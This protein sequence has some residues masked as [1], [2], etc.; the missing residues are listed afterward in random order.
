MIRC[1]YKWAGDYI[2]ELTK[3]ISIL[4]IMWVRVIYLLSLIPQPVS[5]ESERRGLVIGGQNIS[6]IY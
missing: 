1:R 2:A 4:P 3:Y 5:R 6:P